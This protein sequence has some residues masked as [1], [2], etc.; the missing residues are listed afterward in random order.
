MSRDDRSMPLTGPRI[1]AP[2]VG[3]DGV[4][5]RGDRR[6]P[7]AHRHGKPALNALVAPADPE[8]C[9]TAAEKADGRAARG[10]PLGRAHGLPVVVKDVMKVAALTCSVLRSKAREDATVVSRR[11]PTTWPRSS[12]AT[13]Q[14]ASAGLWNCCGSRSSWGG[15]RGGGLN[16]ICRRSAQPIPPKN[17]PNSTGTRGRLFAARGEAPLRRDR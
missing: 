17:S 11:Q 15:D 5:P 8:S 13:H 9:L 6:T 1:S 3:W 14:A 16:R 12:S 10:E 7:C 4:V 2:D